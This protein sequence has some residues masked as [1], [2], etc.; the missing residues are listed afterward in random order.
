[1]SDP[2]ERTETHLNAIDTAKADAHQVLAQLD[3]PPRFTVKAAP[4][5]LMSPPARPARRGHTCPACT[6][7]GHR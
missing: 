1:M 2:P 4:P 5:V 7:G 6:R 3:G